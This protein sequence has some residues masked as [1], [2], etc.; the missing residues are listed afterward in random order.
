MKKHVIKFFSI[1]LLSLLFISCATTVNVNLTRPAKL[2]LNGAKTIAVLPVKP[3]AYYREYD[4]NFGVH[5]L[6]NTFYQLFEI[7]DPDEDAVIRKLRSSIENGLA[8]S[9]YIK[10][11]DSAE[12]ERALKRKY[13]N[14]A[15]V[16]LTGEI[17]Y[18]DVKDIPYEEKKLI[19]P[20]TEDTKAV[21]QII[22][23]WQRYVKLVF[24]YQIIDS[25]NDCVISYQEIKCDNCSVSYENRYRLPSAYRIIEDRVDYAAKSILKELQPDTVAKSSMRLESET[26]EKLL[27][28]RMKAADTL[29]EN[30]NLADS[31]KAFTQLY[32][33]TGL[34]EAGYNAAILEAAMGNLSVAE[35]LMQKLYER[36]PD[37]RVA[38]GLSDIRYEIEQAERLNKQINTSDDSDVD[39]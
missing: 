37:P 26:K 16:Y 18:F 6:I 30:Y 24:R 38:K 4:V 22:T 12:V 14:P 27:K 20:A 17:A 13:L 8:K 34:I 25:S 1:I 35:A 23:W 7:T 32:E 33:E 31:Q 11:I 15:D 36:Y 29:A 9:P 39:F 21:Y 10:L 28:E 3:Y 19:T 5:I 2:D